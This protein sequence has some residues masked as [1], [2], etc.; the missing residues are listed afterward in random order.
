[1]NTSREKIPRPKKKGARK[2]RAMY[3]ERMFTA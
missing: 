3:Q 1:M 2:R